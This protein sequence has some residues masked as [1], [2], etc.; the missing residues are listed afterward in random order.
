MAVSIVTPENHGYNL[1]KLCGVSP[2]LIDQASKE[3]IQISTTSTGTLS[4]VDGK[5]G[6]VLGIVP[7]KGTAI[8]LLQQGKLG[9]ASKESVKYQVEKILKAAIAP[10]EK[11]ETVYDKAADLYAEPQDKDEPISMT[12]DDSDTVVTSSPFAKK[13]KEVLNK[14]QVKL[15]EAKELYQPVFGTSSG[16]VYYVAAIFSG[17]NVALKKA[18]NSMSIRVEGNIKKYQNSLSTLGFTTKGSYASVHFEIENQELYLKTFGAVI[19][20]LG[21]DKLK[22]VGNPLELGK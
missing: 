19:G 2:E 14:E 7:F 20:A 8:S 22:S 6:I 1:I 4:L 17:L 18:S 11:V 3:K 5:T 9:P 13:K 21:F 12:K 15:A 16:S 10:K